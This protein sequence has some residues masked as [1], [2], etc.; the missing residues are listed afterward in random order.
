M[1]R[2][3]TNPNEWG[4]IAMCW[5]MNWQT[6]PSYSSNPLLIFV[7]RYLLISTHSQL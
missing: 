4:V 5:A 7:M 2:K 3:R 6:A 1:L